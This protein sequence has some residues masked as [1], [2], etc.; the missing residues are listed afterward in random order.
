MQALGVSIQSID[1][2]KVQLFGNG[3]GMLPQPNS[4][5]RPDDLQENAILVAGEADG[6]FDDGDYVLFYAQGPHTWKYDATTQQFSHTYNVYSDTAFYFLRINH[7][8]GA[9]IAKR[10]QAA[11]A[12]QTIST[13]TERQFYEKDL[14]NMVYSGR[15][16][17]GED[18]SSFQTT[19]EFS[20]PVSDAVAGTAVK[21]TAALMANSAASSSFAVS[22]NG[23]P[24]G[25]QTIS[26]RGSGE[27]HP[28]GVNSIRT[29]TLNQQQLGTGNAYKVSLA[30]S[31]SGGATAIGYLDYLELQYERQ[32]KL[33][34]EQTAFRA[35]QSIN[36]PVSSFALAGLPAQAQVW[37]VTNPLQPVAQQHSSGRFSA[38]TEV[39]REFVAFQNIST[40]PIPAG[41]VTNQNLHGISGSTDFVIVTH[42]GFLQEAKRLAAHRAQHSSLNVQVVTTTQVYNEFSSG[43]QDVTAIRDFMRMLYT[44]SSKPE[45]EVL[46]L[47]LF[48]D[49]SYDYKNR[50]RTQ[51][52]NFVPVYESRESLH[53][54]NSY[55]SEDYYGF[56]DEDEGEW[57]ENSRGDHLLDIGIGRLP[58]KST[59]EAAI[60]VD[61]IIAY[62]SP[63]HLGSWRSKITFVSDDGDGNE[64][65][66]DAEFLANYVQDNFPKY[67]LN[68]VYLDLFEQI[69]TA[70]GQR[71]P[72]ANAAID[73]AVEQG[74]LIINYTGHGREID[75]AAEQVLT[76]PQISN[77]QNKNNLTFLLT[78]TCEFGRY[79]DPARPSG[80]ELALLHNKGGAIG[81]LTT[82]RPVY[83]NGNRVL[84]RNFFK[85]AFTPINGRMPRLGDVVMQTKNNSINEN[86]SG[87]RGVNNRNFSLLCDPS[88][89]LAYPALEAKITSINGRQAAADTLS[90]LQKV[91]LQGQVQD[92]NGSIA[93]DFNGE[94]HLKVYEKP[95]T[96]YTLGD[97]QGQPV[98]VQVRENVIYDGKASIKSG[99]FE[100]TFV[101]PKDISYTYGHGKISLYAR[102]GTQDALGVDKGVI[103]GGTAPNAAADTTPPTVQ[104]FMDDASFKPGGITGK[105]T[106]LLARLFDENGINTTGTGI[107]HEI[108]AILDGKQDSLLVLSD[109]YTTDLN[110]YQEGGLT[111]VFKDLAPGRH[112]LR[113]KAWDTHNNSAEGYIEFFV[114]NDAGLALEHLFNHPNP[115]SDETTFH[116]NHNRAGEAL[117]VQVQVF[118]L[119]GKLVKTLQTVAEAS[120]AHFAEL[121]WDG[122]DKYNERVAR[123][124]YVYRVTVRSLQDGTKASK[125]EKLII[126]N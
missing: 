124:V 86:T 120:P 8:T 24:L 9:R 68:K 101:V 50:L 95:T 108:T 31:P 92:M 52:T 67:N 88:L 96:R 104:L 19:R 10:E 111:Y 119:S 83:S 33:Y 91:V 97:E 118:T 7:S 61:K 51:N 112:T 98:P 81:L 121:T 21:L 11:G 12:T 69:A 55:S 48:G 75:L 59:A 25:T 74:S 110:N 34:G 102:S 116:F 106:T 113:L 87:S 93:Q 41:K 66:Q 63:S 94:V 56:L 40:K 53:P 99:L 29:Y 18:F 39:L 100:A 4:A 32:L 80:A 2:K 23:Q 6:K 125:V 13:Y 1:P 16:W 17:Y 57:A 126:L 103:I 82:T 28:E 30:F 105:T 115:L 78:A 77:W 45:G 3:G 123:G 107:G 46:Y 122:R 22:L 73:Q 85:S 54:I 14:K 42:P 27:Y 79:D 70:S 49:A 72:A 117:E 35:P 15:E 26:G 71:A 76:L 114:S 62:D 60:L 64:H 20:F 37:D 47:L 43:A 58:A 109:Y 5:P 90:A 38:P 84:N 65:Q 44:R 89:Q 36:Q